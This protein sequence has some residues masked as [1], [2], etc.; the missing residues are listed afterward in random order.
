[1]HVSCF[2]VG[3]KLKIKSEQKTGGK[4]KEPKSLTYDIRLLSGEPHPTI[5]HSLHF[6]EPEVL[7]DQ[8]LNSIKLLKQ[9]KFVFE[10]VSC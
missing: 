8:F 6:A 9:A 10:K 7:L 2:E 4:K 5:Y 1:M 3:S